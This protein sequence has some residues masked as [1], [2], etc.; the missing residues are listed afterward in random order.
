MHNGQPR[1]IFYQDCKSWVTFTSVIPKRTNLKYDLN[2]QISHHQLCGSDEKE[3][4][5]VQ[6]QQEIIQ[7]L[8]S[9]L[10]NQSDLEGNV[11][12]TVGPI[13]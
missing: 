10:S 7:K 3:K 2:H 11:P 1:F 13:I 12:S 6:I 9:R 4:P 8:K 5:I